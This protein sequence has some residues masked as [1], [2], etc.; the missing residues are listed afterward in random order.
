M[1]K[2]GRGLSR[3]ARFTNTDTLS[4]SNLRAAPFVLVVLL[5]SLS[6]TTSC[7]PKTNAFVAPPPPEVT[8]AHPDQRKVT[9]YLE[10]TGTTEPF[11]SVDL[12]ARVSG[13]LEEVHFKPGAHV[14]KGDLLFVIDKRPYQLSVDRA[15]AQVISDEAAFKAADSE[16]SMAE[17][18]VEKRAGSEVDRVVKVGRRETS[19]A[20]IE[21][22]KAILA[23]AK[24]DLEF[25][26]VRS[27][28]DGRITKN[29]VDVGNLIGT[30]GAQPTLLATVVSDKP[31]YVTV[32]ASESDLLMVRRARLAKSPTSEPGQVAPGEWRPVDLATADS[33]EFNVHGHIDYVDP[34]LNPQTGTIKVRCRFENETDNLLPGLFVRLR[35]FQ[36]E[37]E[38]MVVPDI[39]LQAGQSGR[40]AFVVNEKDVVEARPVTIGT[41]DGTMRVVLSGLS[42][43]DRVVVNG[44]QRVRPGMTVKPTLLAA[45]PPNSSPSSPAQNP[46]KPEAGEG[47]K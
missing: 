38:A 43:T 7:K 25:C 35:I 10:S 1:L 5:G 11:Q 16:A 30:G 45:Q 3:F 29:F 4:G 21:A 26:E 37:S 22:S 36:D 46:A 15:Q 31:I 9:R 40:F 28:I 6:A 18:L 8:V 24:L 42:Q 32:D 27:P 39:A 23:S 12:R 14:K 20:A 19:R 17:E 44:L 13:F 33:S 47:S 2:C 41:L 34:A